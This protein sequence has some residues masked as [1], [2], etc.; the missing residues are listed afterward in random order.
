MAPAAGAPGRGDGVV[1][2]LPD[3]PAL[4]RVFDYT[5]P[6]RLGPVAVGTEVRVPLHGRRVRGWVVAVGGTAP[7]GVALRDV[8]AV[9]GVGPPEAVVELARWAAW[10]W[11]GSVPALLRTA[12]APTVVRFRRTNFPRRYSRPGG[13][14]ETGSSRRCRSTSA[15]RASAVP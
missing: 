7:A 9:R 5:L 13:P 11:A 12:A 6:G 1:T 2:V 8:L 14:A 4:R 15:P 3:V 10:R